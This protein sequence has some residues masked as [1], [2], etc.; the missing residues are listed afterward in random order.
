MN[1]DI[2]VMLYCVAG[3]A[4][5]R[6]RLYSAISHSFELKEKQ[7]LADTSTNRQLHCGYISIIN[8]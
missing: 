8:I 5:D 6:L 7:R 2:Q 1:F 3:L 4:K